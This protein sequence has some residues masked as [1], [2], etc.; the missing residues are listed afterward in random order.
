M[1]Q[2]EEEEEEFSRRPLNVEWKVRSSKVRVRVSATAAVQALSMEPR[3]R[4]QPRCLE[5]SS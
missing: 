3:K 4:I 5:G 1:K 2:K